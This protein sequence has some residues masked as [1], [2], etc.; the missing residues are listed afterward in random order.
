[1]S[2]DVQAIDWKRLLEV[3]ERYVQE[4]FENVSF[5]LKYI[6]LDI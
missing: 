6:I 5:R 3:D 4:V 2:F 1:M